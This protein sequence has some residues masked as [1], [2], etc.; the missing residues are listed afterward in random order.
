MN[1]HNEKKTKKDLMEEIKALKQR[2]YELEG[3]KKEALGLKKSNIRS[4][5]EKRE[6]DPFLLLSAQVQ[7]SIESRKAQEA[8]LASNETLGALIVYSPA[9]IVILDR[10]MI[11]KL[12]NPASERMFG[13]KIEE[14]LGTK[15]PIIPQDEEDKFQRLFESHLN[16]EATTDIELRCQRKD[17][18][19]VEI[20]LST[21]P[22][23]NIKGE[24]TGIMSI[25]IDITKRKEAE[26]EKGKIQVQLEQSNKMEAIGRLAGGVAHDFNNLL[27][28]IIGYSDLLLIEKSLDTE[29]SV[30]IEEIKRASERAA[31]LTQQLLAFS[32]KQVLQPKVLLLNQ[33]VSGID[34][35][36]RRLIS[37]DIEF[38]TR[39]DPEL[40]K[41]RADP[42]QIEQVL[43]NLVVNAKDSIQGAGTIT[44]ETGNVSMDKSCCAER[45]EIVPGEYVLLSVSDTGK[46]IDKET[47]EH[48]FEPF[49]T[50]KERGHG[51]GLGLSTV[52]G[53][54]KQSNGYIYV[55]SETDQGTTFNIYLPRIDGS[56]VSEEDKQ[57]ER[58]R[59]K[60]GS[61]HIL[62]VE[63]EEIVRKV[64][65]KVLRDFG[66]T[67]YEAK[68]PNE[69][70]QI[71]QKKRG[72]KIHLM[73]SDVVMP[74][75]SGRALA[76]KL[77]KYNPDMKVLYISG[78]AES[79]I[80]DHGVLIEG[81]P[82]LQKPF[83]PQSLTTKIREM[84]GLGLDF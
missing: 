71:V 59:A 41:V 58:Q 55:N 44:I 35:M 54:V 83:S 67:V 62:V 34:K 17:G 81:I 7:D 84:L 32:R 4:M 30:C 2:V 3:S 42:G 65:C 18:S 38:V 70:I 29:T 21:A 82:F 11:V 49:F 22:I 63:D 48:I 79:A 33:L 51:T 40:G 9:A 46:G 5:E 26:A 64:I 13:W 57:G 80:V 76:D 50:T 36:L 6:K 39:L 12:W 27:T 15:N 10:D 75:M 53:I 23:R 31:S 68:N 1:A 72:C 8:L 66:Y 20:S 60:K 19:L 16:G 77:Q 69:A 74:E 61:E 73:I 37:E 45:P 24:I 47:I 43:L 78:Y 28:A 56:E 52:Y 25:F 14:V